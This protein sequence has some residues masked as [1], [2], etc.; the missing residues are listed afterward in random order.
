[1]PPASSTGLAMRKY[2]LHTVAAMISPQT[3]N[4]LKDWGQLLGYFVAVP[5]A[6][7]G[8]GKAVYEIGANRKQR[9]EDLRWRQAQ[10]AKDL[11][12]DIHNHELAKHA[13]HM[14]DW[15]DGSAEYDVNGR[16][17]TISYPKVLEALALNNGEYCEEYQAYVRD[18]FDWFLYR[19]DRIEHYI[20]RG[21]I[22]FGDVEDV[23]LVYAREIGFHQDVF[24]SF[25]Q[26][27]EYNLARQF[28]ARYY[29]H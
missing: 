13:I 21:L 8:L 29:P 23:F 7:A 17:V 18:C 9:A 26:F 20:R 16:K 15:A 22:Q 11:L 2:T 5:V 10:A 28:F 19:V 12:D 3:M 25:L 6:I 24:D 4:A 27:H 1:M 14:L